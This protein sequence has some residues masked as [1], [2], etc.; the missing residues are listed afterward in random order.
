MTTTRTDG[1]LGSSWEP[2]EGWYYDSLMWDT[3]EGGAGL[4]LRGCSGADDTCDGLPAGCGLSGDQYG[5]DQCMGQVGLASPKRCASSSDSCVKAVATGEIAV[6]GVATNR[7]RFE[8][9]PLAGCFAG[10]CD[11]LRAAWLNTSNG[12]V[13]ATLDH[14]ECESHHIA[15][16]PPLG[17]GACGVYETSC[18]AYL[19]NPGAYTQQ[20]HSDDNAPGD[21]YDKPHFLKRRLLLGENG[22][23]RL[24][25][26]FHT[27]SSCDASSARFV[28]HVLT[29]ATRIEAGAATSSLPLLQGAKRIERRSAL[30]AYTPSPAHFVCSKLA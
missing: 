9:L 24:T 10:T 7:T 27:D 16:P 28:E 15:E 8:R 2:Q 13:S 30:A 11:E 19:V 21:A 12:T 23:E 25:Q 3:W 26:S 14:W 22:E 17:E 20:G 18:E 1:Q 5:G 6:D 29:E 4:Q